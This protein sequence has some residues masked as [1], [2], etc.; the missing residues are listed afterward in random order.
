MFVF[1]STIAVYVFIIQ[2]TKLFV[3]LNDLLLKLLYSFFNNLN[4]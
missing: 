2:Y 3:K 4:Y 1:N